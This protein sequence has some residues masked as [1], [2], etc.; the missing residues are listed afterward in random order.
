MHSTNPLRT[1]EA[2]LGEPL[3][4]FVLNRDERPLDEELTEAQQMVLYD[5]DSG[6]IVGPRDDP[7]IPVAL[8]HVG[9]D[10]STGAWRLRARCGGERPE[11]IGEDEVARGLT[12]IARDSYAVLLSPPDLTVSFVAGK[13]LPASDPLIGLSQVVSIHPDCDRVQSELA[14]EAEGWRDVSVDTLMSRERLPRP[15]SLESLIGAAAERWQHQPG[16]DAEAFMRCVADCLADLRKLGACDPTMGIGLIGLRGM[17]LVESRSEV[18]LSVGLLR[19]PTEHERRFSPFTQLAESADA[20]LVVPIELTLT[21]A[22]PSD[23]MDGRLQLRLREIGRAVS[24]ASALA[25]RGEADSPAAIAI[26]WITESTP[27]G[28]RSAFRPTV[29]T[30]WVPTVSYG[31]TE[32]DALR[33]WVEK[34]DDVELGNIAIAVERLLR[35]IF[36]IEPGES[37]IDAVIAWENLVGARPETTF[38]VTAG[39]TVL[40]EDDPTKRLALRKELGQIY[41]QR[42][43]IL[44]GDELGGESPLRNRAIQIGLEAIARLIERRPALLQLTKSRQRV[45]RL[46]LAV[47]DGPAG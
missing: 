22:G 6:G 38:R 5:L 36:E 20:V 43:R 33:H 14:R 41:E 21:D 2:A 4:R 32:L 46:L 19:P 25:K 12:M 45:D 29:S 28:S 40:C 26:A 8:S 18:E 11:P 42:S 31:E 30:E 27:F 23:P 13:S 37:L 3:L 34:V 44:H 15:P 35:A 39:L 16:A 24:L 10:G 9:E 1:W 47:D 17:E 7:R